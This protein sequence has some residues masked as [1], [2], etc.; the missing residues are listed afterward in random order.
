MN[1]LLK[2]TIVLDDA[3]INKR[4]GTKR[5]TASLRRVIEDDTQTLLQQQRIKEKLLLKQW[6]ADR[7]TD[8]K[9]RLIIRKQSHDVRRREKE[10]LSEMDESEYDEAGCITDRY[11]WKHAGCDEIC[12][13]DN[14]VQY[15][16]GYLASGDDYYL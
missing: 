11:V 3:Y 2:K 9:R 1:S 10:R 7:T 14:C 13:A 15:M 12:K 6:K 4:R 8:K 16:L 5:K